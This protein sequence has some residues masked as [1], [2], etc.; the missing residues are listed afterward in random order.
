MLNRLRREKRFSTAQRDGLLG[1]SY[2]LSKAELLT[3]LSVCKRSFNLLKE[4]FMGYNTNML[5]CPPLEG[6]SWRV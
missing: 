2:E 1:K 3:L 5:A 6:D 4:D